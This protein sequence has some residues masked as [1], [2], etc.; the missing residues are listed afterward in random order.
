LRPLIL[1]R[2]SSILIQII[3]SRIVYYSI[4]YNGF[5]IN[6]II[7]LQIKF[8]IIKLSIIKFCIIK[9]SIIKFC[10]IKLSTIK[11]CII[12][13]SIIKFY[14][15]LFVCLAIVFSCGVS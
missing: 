12:K 10:I 1:L 6:L 15:Y 4:K 14:L 5:Y 3:R 11:F 8:C 7:Q 13:L 2:P 9:L